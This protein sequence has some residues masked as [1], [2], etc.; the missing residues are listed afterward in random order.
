[1]LLLH[2]LANLPGFFGVA[3]QASGDETLFYITDL[4]T[5]TVF[6]NPFEDYAAI[7]RDNVQLFG[8]TQPIPGDYLEYFKALPGV[9]TGE[10][11]N[12]TFSG[13][14]AR[15]MSFTIG[16]NEGGHAIPPATEPMLLTFFSPSGITY[17]YTPGDSG[18]LY[19][20]E[21]ASKPTLAEVT[22][23]P[24]ADVFFASFVLDGAAS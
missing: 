5:A 17:T 1:M 7:G 10:I 6:T 13:L 9:T 3:T 12:T 8:A 18:T 23:Y 19:L 16:S 21:L 4:S 22:D 11:T 24:G 14:P 20:F 2:F 15:S